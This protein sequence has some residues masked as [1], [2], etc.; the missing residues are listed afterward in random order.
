[1]TDTAPHPPPTDGS[2]AAAAPQR[3]G[4]SLPTTRRATVIGAGS[5]GTAVAVLLA[6]AG[7]RTT[8]QARTVEQAQSLE[9]ERE[10]RVY[11]PGV[12]F[13]RELRIESIAGGVARADYVF[14][15]VPS[16]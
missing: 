5:F 2:P 3:R 6:R 7:V 10:N 1:M 15:A 9:R 11:L 4:V 16:R 13:P 14:L 8:L 12:E